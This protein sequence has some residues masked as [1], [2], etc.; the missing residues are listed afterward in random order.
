MLKGNLTCTEISRLIFMY[1]DDKLSDKLRDAIALHLRNCPFC[2]EKYRIIKTLFSSI[3]Q[4]REKIQKK[5]KKFRIISAFC[6]GE[7]PKACIEKIEHAIKHSN[8]IKNMVCKINSTTQLINYASD[9][10]FM[11]TKLNLE[12]TVM[13]RLLNDNPIAKIKNFI[14][15]M[16]FNFQKQ[17]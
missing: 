6:D 12:K 3:R 7:I 11:N 8:E 15:K 13:T 5:F 14:K 10:R 17:D 2:M 9:K 4:K 1:I 16:F